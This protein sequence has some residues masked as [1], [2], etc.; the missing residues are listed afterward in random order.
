VILRKK[1][2]QAS[3]VV[4]VL[5]VAQAILARLATVTASPERKQQAPPD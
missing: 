2:R 4:D 3:Y 1:V 5:A